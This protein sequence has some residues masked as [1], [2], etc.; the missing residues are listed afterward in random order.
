M[1]KS[2]RRNGAFALAALA[3]L[4]TACASPHL[5]ASSTSQTEAE[6]TAQTEAEISS[7]TEVE[8]TASAEGSDPDIVTKKEDLAFQEGDLL[9]AEAFHGEAYLKVLI[10]HD[11]QYNYP[12][13]NS[14]IFAP[15]SR[16]MWHEH[17]GMIVI[18][19]GGVGYYQE[20][21]KPAQILRKGDIVNIPA[22][23]RHWHGATADSWFSQIVIY[24]SEYTA[25]SGTPEE[26][27]SDDAY[28]NLE[29]EEYTGD[30]DT[31]GGELTF[32][33]GQELNSD[34]FSGTAFINA[35][36]GEGN[37][38][39]A[40]SAFFVT[41]NPGTI[42]NWHRHPGGQI[43]IA[44]DGIGYHQLEGGEVEVLHPGDVAFCPPGETHWHG[45]SA[46]TTFAHIAIETNPGSGDVEWYDRISDE[47]YAALPKE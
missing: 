30:P 11:D 41:F 2:I 20:E 37:A 9:P 3:A 7:Q 44:T 24:D 47:D 38:A 14:L 27:V 22:G 6:S 42:N 23:T 10:Q 33:K 21:G 25:D 8:S 26:A 39:G 5:A 18:A 46:D 34:N 35:L 17:G 12:Q 32:D 13:T 43:L 16:S 31:Q 45:G 28:A 1:K 15:G 29:T 40:S 19:T 4:F 36:I